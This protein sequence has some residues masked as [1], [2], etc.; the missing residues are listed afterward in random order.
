MFFMIIYIWDLTCVQIKKSEKTADLRLFFRPDTVTRKGKEE[1]AWI[2]M[3]CEFV[4]FITSL[5]IFD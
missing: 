1:E 2:C 3:L 4:I 5:Y